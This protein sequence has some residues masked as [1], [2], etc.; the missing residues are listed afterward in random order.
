MESISVTKIR[1]ELKKRIHSGYAHYKEE[2]LLNEM[3]AIFS[4]AKVEKA[5]IAP[6]E[7]FGMKL[8]DPTTIRSLL[9][10]N[11]PLSSIGKKI[12]W[13]CFIMALYYYGIPLSVLGRWFS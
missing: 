9:T 13:V 3:M 4:S 10:E 5:G 8:S 1:G 12:K 7:S 6:P 2:Y 11:A